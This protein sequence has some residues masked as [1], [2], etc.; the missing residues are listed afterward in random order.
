MIPN[1]WYPIYETRRVRRRPV[2]VTRLGA[3]L[4]L[5]RDGNGTVRCARDVCP[6]RAAR[7]SLGRIRDG[8][9]ECPYHG[10]RFDGAGRCVLIPANGRGAPV[11]R[12]FDLDLREIREAHGLVWLW[13]G[14]RGAATPEVPWID[15]GPEPGGTSVTVA[16]EYPFPYLRVMENMTD[17]H[18]VAFVHRRSIPGAG[19]RVVDVEDHTDR[20]SLSVS[21]TLRHERPS[22]RLR[23]DYRFTTKLRLP[24]L[25]TIE[26]LPGAR[27]IASATPVDRN[28]TWLWARYRQDWVP[29]WLGGRPLARVLAAYDMS[30][31]FWLQDSR[32]L[33]NQQ[34]KDPGDISHYHLFEA[35]R[36]VALYFGMRKRALLD[37]ARPS[38]DNHE[39]IAA[40]D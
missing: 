17:F 13:Y 16:R 15:E 5:W 37:A 22:K 19:T 12:G 24:T 8:C 25:A 36:G 34:L 14:E 30:I 32:M 20:A 28:R 26:V 11:P 2:G 6:H 38:G 31:V 10:L 21:L 7:L 39:A 23:A 29:W 4:V 1:Q 40:A 3:Q 27:F 9:L 33:R 35:D 18:H